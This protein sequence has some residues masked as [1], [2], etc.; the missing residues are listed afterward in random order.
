MWRRLMSRLN[1]R[2]ITREGSDLGQSGRASARNER[3]G[4][5]FLGIAYYAEALSSSRMV[6]SCCCS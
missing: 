1:G 5:P 3:S 4:S 2:S 6:V